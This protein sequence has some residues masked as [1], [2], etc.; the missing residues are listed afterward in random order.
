MG[1]DYRPPSQDDDTNELF[2]K[3]LRDASKSTAL[4]LTGDF[5]LQLGPST[6]LLQPKSEDS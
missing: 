4:V 6:Q 2:L 5:S 1:T 3:E